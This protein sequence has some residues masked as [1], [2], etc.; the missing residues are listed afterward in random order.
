ME[1]MTQPVTPPP[2]PGPAMSIWSRSVAMFARPAQAWLGLERKGQW[3]FPLLLCVLV[4]VIGAGLTYQRA[5][6]PTQLAQYDRMAEAGRIPPEAVDRLERQASSPT[7]MVVT[8]ASIAIVLPLM[9]LAFALLPWV[10]AG[11]LLGRRFRYRDAFVVTS[12][13]GLVSIPAQILTSVLAWT[14]ATMTN[15]H[16]GFG[17]LLPVEDPP[18]KLIVG[19]GTFLDQGIGPFALWYLLVLALGATALSGGNRRSVILALGGVWL[20]V[21]AIISV[22]AGVFAPGA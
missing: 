18:S 15:L 13:A 8:L 3:W 22:L 1:T 2:E 19:L 5:V 4:S 11:F 14:N 17:V 7:A 10:A 16:I 9:N 6:V 12:W 21:I 20:F